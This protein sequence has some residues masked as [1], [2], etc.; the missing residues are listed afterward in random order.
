MAANTTVELLEAE[1]EKFVLGVTETY[2]CYDVDDETQRQQKA[3]QAIENFIIQVNNIHLNQVQQ[4]SKTKS[5]EEKTEQ[6][7]SVESK[8]G[9]S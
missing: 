1:Q 5:G 9:Q 6:I 8:Q 7:Q 3:K 2:R 4:L